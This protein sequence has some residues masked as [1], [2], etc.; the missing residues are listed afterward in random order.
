MPI[1]ARSARGEIVD[2]DILQIKQQ[3]AATPVQVGTEE[4][5]RFIDT[6]DGVKPK[7]VSASEIPTGLKDISAM[8]M[9]ADFVVE[10]EPVEE[11]VV[12]VSTKKA[13]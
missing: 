2:F 12:E 3:L 1:T 6:K 4:R 5:R 7:T 9:A 13:K 8:S 11:P 10:E